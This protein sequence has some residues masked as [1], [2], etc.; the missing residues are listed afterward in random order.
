MAKRPHRPTE[1]ELKEAEESFVLSLELIRRSHG[2]KL[3][4][5]PLKRAMEAI[6]NLG[7]IRDELRLLSQS[8]GKK[9]P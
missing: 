7:D 4:P 2:G 8:H 5:P 1:E 9:A 6:K 3:P